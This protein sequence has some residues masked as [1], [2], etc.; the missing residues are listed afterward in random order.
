MTTRSESNPN[1]LPLDVAVAIEENAPTTVPAQ[2]EDAP[3]SVEN[4]IARLTAIRD[5]LFWLQSVWAVSLSHDVAY[6]ADSYRQVFREL[7]DQLRKQD[8]DAADKLIAGH[9]ALLLADLS[10]P[11]PT[12]P[13]ATQRWFELAGEVRSERSQPPQPKPTGYVP[14]GLQRFL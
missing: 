9:E 7:S 1:N 2:R 12:L 13:I 5:R 11:K 10:P 14:D 4:L 6:E 8:A 3:A